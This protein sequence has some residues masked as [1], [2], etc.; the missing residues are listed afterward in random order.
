MKLLIV[1]TLLSLAL[2][3][4]LLENSSD[5]ESCLKTFNTYVCRSDQSDLYSYCC[6]FDSETDQKSKACTNNEF[7]SNMTLTTSMEYHACPYLP[8]K[9]TDQ[10]SSKVELNYVNRTYQMK[11]NENRIGVKTGFRNDDTCFYAIY[12][13]DSGYNFDQR[14]VDGEYFIN[15]SISYANS[16]VYMNNGTNLTTAADEITLGFNTGTD[17]TYEAANNTIFP[18]IVA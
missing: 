4:S 1:I 7:C 3:Y 6:S 10:S 8:L 11:T 16:Y 15:V 14:E 12:A 2:S 13:P 9:C 17:F 18:V 5:C